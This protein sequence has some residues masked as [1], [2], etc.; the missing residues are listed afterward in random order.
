[1]LG[2]FLTED[3]H[4]KG[5]EE[6]F[7]LVGKTESN[8]TYASLEYPLGQSSIFCVEYG[9]PIRFSKSNIQAN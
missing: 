9:F 2:C 8:T 4:I 3:I 6:A 5:Y 1:M 7:K